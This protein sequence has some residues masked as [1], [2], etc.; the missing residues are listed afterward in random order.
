[1]KFCANC[2]EPISES[3]K[4]CTNCGAKVN[5]NAKRETVYDGAIHKCPHCGE[6]LRPF[7]LVCPSCGYEIQEKKA[8]SSVRDFYQELSMVQSVTQK[9][10]MI[11]NFPIPNTK[12]DIIEFMII[13]SSNIV[14]EDEKDIYE[15]W[16]A[17]FE[18]VYQKALIL[19]EKDDDFDKIQNIYNKYLENKEDVNRR[20]ML[21]IAIRNICC[22]IAL[23]I[24]FMALIVDYRGGNGSFLEL[25]AAILVIV[26]A[27]NLKKRES[28][29]V[30]YAAVAIICFCFILLS[31]LFY[32]GSFTQLSGAIGLIIVAVNYI[33][34]QLK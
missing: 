34:T 20:R 18:Q 33:K 9:D 32:N 8:T 19:F 16:T 21:D 22:V 23:V 30:D 2:G 10:H 1:M 7:E 17:K 27:A 3:S 6:T 5:S 4:F 26:S 29:V 31:G 28:L 13:A 11:R 25:I 14:G 15:A 12:A 24:L